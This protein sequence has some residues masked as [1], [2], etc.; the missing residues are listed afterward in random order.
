MQFMRYYKVNVYTN[1]RW[2]EIDCFLTVLAM[3]SPISVRITSH[4]TLVECGE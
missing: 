3:L 4:Q 1:V 2:S